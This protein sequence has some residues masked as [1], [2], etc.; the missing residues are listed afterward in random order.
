NSGG[1]VENIENGKNGFIYTPQDSEDFTQKLKQLVESFDLRQAMGANGRKQ[2][3]QYSWDTTV[4]NLV[5]I[6]QQ[7]IRDRH[8]D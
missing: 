2:V 8:V 3:E 5:E 7:Q 4:Q 1:V 6:W